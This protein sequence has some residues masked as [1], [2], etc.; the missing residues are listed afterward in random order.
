MHSTLFAS[1]SYYDIKLYYAYVRSKSG[2]GLY[3]GLLRHCR[4]L[5]VDVEGQQ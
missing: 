4:R 3:H 2:E 1:P 5:P